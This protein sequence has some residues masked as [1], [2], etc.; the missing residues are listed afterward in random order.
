MRNKKVFLIGSR[1]SPLAKEQTKI[2]VKKLKLIGIEN[3][4]VKYILSKGDTFTHKKFKDAGGKGL[5]TNELDKLVLNR[6]IDIAVHSSKDIPSY[7]S[8]GLEISAFLKRENPRDVLV[9]RRSGIIKIEDIPHGSIFGS[10][11]PRRISYIKHYRP[12]IIIKNLRG[13]ID[14]RIKKVYEGKVFATLLAQAGLARLKSKNYK[15]NLRVVP[16]SKILPAPGQGVIAIMQRRDNE[17][18]KK[19]LKLIDH[20]KTRL[21]ISAEREL[22][23]EIKGDCFTPIGV[24]A[25]IEKACLKIRARL[26]STDGLKYVEV[27]KT[28]CAMDAKHLGRQCAKEILSKIKFKFKK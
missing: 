23:K 3:I 28:S 13:N 1:Q 19:K 22:I 10:S 12:D 17:H 26:F 7:I 8:R 14:T 20:K 16:L 18:L 25:N 27:R 9:T 2:V 5:F 15:I 6:E 24:Y 4:K 21:I 11:S